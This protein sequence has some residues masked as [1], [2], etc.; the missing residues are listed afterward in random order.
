MLKAFWQI[1]TEAH[2]TSIELRTGYIVAHTVEAGT[3]NFMNV[4]AAEAVKRVQ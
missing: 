1:V 3:M 4:C 2:L